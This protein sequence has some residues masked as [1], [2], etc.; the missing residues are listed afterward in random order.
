MKRLSVFVVGVMMDSIYG[1][2]FAV[3]GAA[4]VMARQELSPFGW[5]TSSDVLWLLGAVVV[6]S[7][8]LNIPGEVRRWTKPE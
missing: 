7:A 6:V 1:I 8:A 5:F 3:L 2:I 4:Y